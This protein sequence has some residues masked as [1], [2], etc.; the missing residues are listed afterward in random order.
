MTSKPWAVEEEVARV[1]EAAALEEVSRAQE[2]AQE[3]AALEAAAAQV[4][5]AEE[6]ARAWEVAP[7]GVV[8]SRLS[9]TAWTLDGRPPRSPSRAWLLPGYQV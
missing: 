5:R 3:A 7:R 9:R 4:A 8:G 1:R 2:G 6:A